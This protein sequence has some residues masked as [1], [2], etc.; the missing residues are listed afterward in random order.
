MIQTDLYQQT[1]AQ[2]WDHWHQT[3]GG[4][5]VL[6]IA[7]AIT[8]RYGQRFIRTGRRVSIRLIWEEMRDSIVFIRA[9]MISKGI[10]L[11]KLDG[12][13]LND[14]LHAYV[15]RHIME[16]KPEWKG[17]FELRELGGNRK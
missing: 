14:H 9:R 8:A 12:F 13:A 2:Q 7:Y 3:P 11:E 5:Q 4:R 15:A 1:P 6:R 10:M 16:H 17:L